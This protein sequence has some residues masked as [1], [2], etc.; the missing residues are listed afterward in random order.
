MKEKNEQIEEFIKL[1]ALVSKDIALFKKHL[2]KTTLTPSEI[3]V[4]WGYHAYRKRDQKLAF[5]H[6]K[7]APLNCPLIEGVRLYLLGLTCNHF[8]KF[9]F[10]REYLLKAQKKLD[11]SPLTHF[12]LLNL[13]T[14]LFCYSNQNILNPLSSLYTQIDQISPMNEYEEVLK[15]LAK[16]T[17]LCDVRQFHETELCICEFEKSNSEFLSSF[18]A[19]FQLLRIINYFNQENFAKCYEALEEYNQKT[20]FRCNSN[21]RYLKILLDHILSD[22]VLY[23][24]KYDFE[25][26][27]EQ[28]DQLM[29]IKS[30]DENSLEEAHR[31]WSMLQKHNPEIYRANFDFQGNSNLFKLALQKKLAKMESD[32][33]LKH[34]EQL[35]TIQEKLEY[36]FNSGSDKIK[37]ER[38]ISLLWGE[39]DSAEARTKLRRALQYFQQKN[40]VKL[41]SYQDCYQILKKAS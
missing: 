33:N 13:T 24:Y 31:Y 29:V 7:S 23:V 18:A 9:A 20:G 3:K 2:K 27:Q 14:L 1:Y 8:G 30:L 4:L 11:E 39:E 6:L 19:S 26:S 38:L 25:D 36:I 40:N 35:P 17:Y 21:Y 5:T 10:A 12:K 37:K 15:L 22:K 41:K 34:L 16:A 28:F 32:Y